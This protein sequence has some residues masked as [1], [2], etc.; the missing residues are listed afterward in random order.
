MKI[1]EMFDNEGLSIARSDYGH[2]TVYTDECGKKW[3]RQG[4]IIHC[5]SIVK[6]MNIKDEE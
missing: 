5:P 3:Y 1:L 4:D 2:I 6:T